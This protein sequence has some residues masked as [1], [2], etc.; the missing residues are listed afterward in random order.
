[1]TMDEDDAIAVG[2]GYVTRGDAA[3]ILDDPLRAT[4]GSTSVSVPGMPVARMVS[5]VVG[6]SGGSGGVPDDT[7]H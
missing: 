7:L 3:R 1:M 2:E 4:D 5:Y 6:H